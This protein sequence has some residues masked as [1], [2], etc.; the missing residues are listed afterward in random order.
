MVTLLDEIKKEDH[1][2]S[3]KG[4]Q[5]KWFTGDVWYK[6]DYTGYEGLSEYI[7]SKLLM[8]S[9]LKEEQ[10]ILYDTEE[11]RYKRQQ[12]LGCSSKNFLKEG[13]QL[14]TLER[15][16]LHNYGE[17]LNKSLYS[18]ANHTE[19]LRFLVNQTERCTGL[20]E[21]GKYMCQMLTVDTLFL[22]EDRHTH[23]IAVL[24]NPKGEYEYCP[25]FD[26]GAALL[27]DTTMDYPM[28]ESIENLLREVE[29]KTFCQSFDE[30]L[31][32]AEELYGQEVRFDFSRKDV[33]AI[34]EKEPYYATE[35]KDRVLSII[36]ERKRKY[37][38]LFIN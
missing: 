14:I 12:F 34:L 35:I 8:Q 11:I 26:N 25:I 31:D 27:S 7:V 28:E 13:Y 1:R 16:F 21:F 3:S 10:F 4:N 29:A 22:N 18:I 5:L 30:Q 2:Q 36:M 33:T 9:N 37:Q 20:K 24:R 32:I 6:A 17:S 23:N 19:R 15:L 38:Y